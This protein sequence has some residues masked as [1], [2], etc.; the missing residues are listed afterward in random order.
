[1]GHRIE[2]EEI[3]LIINSYRGIQRVCCVLDA[4]KN[5]ITAFYVGSMEGKQI[6][7]K[8]HKSLPSYMI[9]TAFN[10]LPELPISANGKIDRGKLLA[11]CGGKQ[12]EYK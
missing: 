2:L 10:S 9:P 3:E 7:K 1:M 8:M 5:R 6:Q 11:T 4:D 12:N